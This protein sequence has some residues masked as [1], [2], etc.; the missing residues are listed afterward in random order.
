LLKTGLAC[1]LFGNPLIGSVAWIGD[2][3]TSQFAAVMTNDWVRRL[4]LEQT[5]IS[6]PANSA[7]DKVK[8]VPPLRMIACFVGFVA[9]DC[10]AACSLLD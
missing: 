5:L 2:E 1:K 3:G 9:M 7:M 4:N 8:S 6:S 10:F